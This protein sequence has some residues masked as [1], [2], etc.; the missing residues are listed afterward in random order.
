M[1]VANSN[2]YINSAVVE[3]GRNC[4]LSCRHCYNSSSPNRSAELCVDRIKNRISE[5]ANLGIKDL[6]ITGGEPTVHPE[7]FE[8]IGHACLKNLRIHI[9][10]NACFKEDI[11]KKLAD[12]P[13]TLIRVSFDGYADEHD[14]LRGKGSFKQA[15]YGLEMLQKENI[16]FSISYHIHQKLKSTCF[17]TLKKFLKWNCPINVGPVLPFGRAKNTKDLCFSENEYKN[18]VK[19]FLNL[20]NKFITIS[21]YSCYVKKGV[22]SIDARGRLNICCLRREKIISGNNVTIEE[23]LMRDSFYSSV[24]EKTDLNCMNC[25]FEY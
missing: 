21:N 24:Q 17:E 4:N 7:L 22:V 2:I 8:I 11:A 9:S 1:K 10:S 16:T 23:C 14:F 15:K 6:W 3:L 20:N 12:Y 5:I 13:I 19:S 18:L 25:D